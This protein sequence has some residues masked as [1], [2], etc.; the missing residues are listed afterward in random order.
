MVL[1]PAVCIGR[2]VT[3][4]YAHTPDTRFVFWTVNVTDTF[5]YFCDRR[6]GLTCATTTANITTGAHTDQGTD[7][8]RS[9]DR[10]FRRTS[11]WLQNTAWILTF[12][13]KASESGGTI[14]I[15]FAFRSRFGSAPNVR[16]TDVSRRAAASSKVIL[17]ATFCPRGTNVIVDTRIDTL[18]V[19]TGAVVGTIIVAATA[20][21]ITTYVSV[22]SITAQTTALCSVAIRITFSIGSTRIVDQTGVDA[23]GIHT[24]LSRFTF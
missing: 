1:D 14:R 9:H 22:S 24:R 3:R 21:N 20:N 15:F 5:S 7:R 8:Y 13:V 18:C 16:V 6:C 17:H 12:C 4:C 10:A 2:A 11:T 23:V 19:D